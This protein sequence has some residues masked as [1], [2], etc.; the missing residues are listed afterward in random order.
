MELLFKDNEFTDY[1]VNFLKCIASK[2]Q[3]H[4][5]DLFY[6]NIYNHFPI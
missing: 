2:M 6:N 3:E 4:P 1:F 5:I